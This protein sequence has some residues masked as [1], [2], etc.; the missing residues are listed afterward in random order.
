MLA[1]AAVSAGLSSSV[2][3]VFDEAVGRPHQ[4]VEDIAALLLSGGDDCAQYGEVVCAASG[5][6]AAGDFLAQF[7]HAQVALG[8]VVGEGDLWVGEEA[9]GLVS[10][11]MQA[12]GEVMALAPPRCPAPAGRRE[13]RLALMERQRLDKQPVV[14]ARNPRA[15]S[16][17]GTA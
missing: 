14:A 13:R 12:Q 17:P 15:R 5:A 16:R 7:H 6:E 4:G 9:Q 10:A 3:D 1:I 11:L 8:L 2:L